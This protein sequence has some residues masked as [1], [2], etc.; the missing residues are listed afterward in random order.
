MKKLIFIII[1]LLVSS[2]ASAQIA[3]DSLSSDALNQLLI[4][5]IERLAEET[6]EE[7]DYEELLDNYIFYSENPININSDDIV[8]LLELRLINVF[9]YEALKDYR[10]FYGDFLFLDELEMVEGFD[11]QTVNIIKSIVYVGVDNSKEK[12]TLQK[13]A[14]YGKHQIVT[15]YEQILENQQGYE[16]VDDEEML[17]H[18]GQHFLG[19]PQKY[20]IKYTYNYRNKIR[21]GFAAEKD[22]GEMFFTDKI[23][24]TIKT[25]LGDKYHKGF[26]IYGFHVYAND[27]GLVKDVALGDYQL[28]FGQGL[29]LW[30]G[31]SFGKTVDGSS[32]MKQG[33][34]L[35]PKTSST[36]YGYF[37]GA[38]VTLHHKDF[39][40]TFFY[41][42]RKIDANI[43]VADSL[44]EVEMVSSIQETGY[45]RTIGELLDR[46]A[47]RQQVIGGHLAYANSHL[48]IGYTLHHTRLSAELLLQ[49]SHYNQFYFQGKQLTNQG[50]DFKY[51]KNKF[52][53]FGEAAMSDN[54]AF[55]G[56]VGVTARPTGYI[57]FT[58]FYRNYDKK[59]QN[60]FANAYGES[61][62]GQGEEGLYFG[63]QAVIA[64]YWNLLVYTDFFRLTW[65][66]SQVYSPSWGHDYYAKLSHQVSRRA[67]WNLV[68]RSK[69]K[70]K[71][72]TDAFVFSQYPI[73]YT[74]NSVR[75][76]ISYKIGSNWS[77]GNRADYEHYYN[78]DNSDSQGFFICQDVAY[79]PEGK[80][81]SISFRY[82]IFD[83]DD[84]YSRIYAYENDVLYSFSVPSLYDKGMRIYL[85]GHVKLFNSLSLYAR[86][87]RTIYSNKDEISSGPT[88]I[89][90][91]HKTDLKIEAIW[92]F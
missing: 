68:L 92:K 45:H 58:L 89:K 7:I 17:E 30:S 4:E 26:D 44:N 3:V 81:Y 8:N 70:M 10:K 36:E 37:R 78:D 69:T 56:L 41:S 67:N 71:N 16:T 39:Y 28:S 29:T 27:L 48:E 72:S 87:G 42:N 35:K 91:N 1:S 54:K 60:L 80:P 52:A 50:I 57:N 18:Q 25:V 40:G 62:R 84:Y 83:T 13:M 19:S 55:A 14:K 63:L 20:Q 43:S 24:D 53:F 75:F 32:V 34:G 85:L 22:P 15:R 12:V 31:M 51:V 49:P 77:L 76:N 47:I 33:R 82:A 46:N 5:Q 6:E 65:L 66:T 21:F 73:F 88:L 64:P 79:K 23:S 11:E 90:G 86:I 9:Q 74:K 59:Y 61:S 2:L 38:A